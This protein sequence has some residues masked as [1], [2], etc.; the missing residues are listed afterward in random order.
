MGKKN[1]AQ[2]LLRFMVGDDVVFKRKDATGWHAG[3]VEELWYRNAK[4]PDNHPSHAYRLEQKS[5]LP[6]G[7]T[8]SMVTIE[9]D[10]EACVRVMKRDKDSALKSGRLATS[11]KVNWL[12]GN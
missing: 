3:T 10:T 4:W 6:S 11:R 12:S 9:E 7:Q 8:N 2:G 1:K 5:A